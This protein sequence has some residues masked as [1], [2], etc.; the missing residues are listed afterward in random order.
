MKRWESSLNTMAVKIVI[1]IS[2]VIFFTETLVMYLLPHIG[3]LSV[4]QEN[5]LDS[6]LLLI[7]LVPSLYYFIFIPFSREMNQRITIENNLRENVKHLHLAGLIFEHSGEAIILTDENNKILSCNKRYVEI[8]GYSVDELLGKTLTEFGDSS[9]DKS[10]SIKIMDS[11][12][13]L[14]RWQGEVNDKRKNG[15][16][17]QKLLTVTTLK[18]HTGHITNYIRIFSDLTMLKKAEE[19]RQLA[20]FDHLTGLPNRVLLLDVMK[21][22]MEQ[23]NHDNKM[24]GVFFL[25]LDHFKQINDIWGHAAG[26]VFLKR[27]AERLKNSVRDTDVVSRHGGDEFIVILPNLKSYDYALKVSKTIISRMSE[28]FMINEQKMQATFSIGMSLYPEDGDDPETLLKKADMA[29][30]RAKESGRNTFEPYSKE[31]N[32]KLTRRINLE[33]NMRL[34]LGNEE[35][36]VYYQPVIDLYDNQV[37]SLEALLRW[38]HPKYGFIQPSEFIT[39]AEDTGLITPIGEWLLGAVCKQN[40]I[41]HKNQL[42]DRPVRIAVNLSAR[43][44][45]ERDLALSISNILKETG[46]SGD[47]LTLELTESLMMADIQYSITVIKALKDLGIVIALDD[48]GVGYSSLNY[49]RRFPIDILKIDRS[50]VSEIS[51][52]TTDGANAAA[53]VNAIIVLAHNLKLK[54]V[55]EGVETQEQ[56]DLLKK[57][58]CDEI[59]GYL[60]SRALPSKEIAQ[61]LQGVKSDRVIS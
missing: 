24:V 18:D 17:Y 29:M 23:A 40:L 7:A 46:I 16:V 10:I 21:K 19:A 32:D 55:G 9:N 20:F 26:D 14:G 49:L 8:T 12:A 3:S 13:K 36:L 37:N 57:Y 31:M 4:W 44:F 11:V 50:F 52:D 43:Q 35:F 51:L 30:Y 60:V 5:F 41:W 42:V 38:K 1:S 58:G 2:I 54:V 34:A 53:I 56:L 45:N 47:S 27:V 15:D 22:S 39:I 6:T 25:D 61:Y 48:F 28:P 59:Q 33:N